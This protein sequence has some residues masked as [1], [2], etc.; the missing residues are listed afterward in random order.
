MAHG[1]G[2]SMHSFVNQMGDS[3]TDAGKKGWLVA[4]LELGA[5]LGVLLSGVCRHRLERHV[6]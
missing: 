1:N 3:A 2:I 4:I 6:E 5:W